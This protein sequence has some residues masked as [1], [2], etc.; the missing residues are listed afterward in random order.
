MHSKEVSELINNLHAA[1]QSYEEGWLSEDAV[2]DA[3]LALEQHLP[4]FADHHV[5]WPSQ[6][7]KQKSEEGRKNANS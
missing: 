5:G 6:L 3:M 1:A 7:P 2:N 4:G